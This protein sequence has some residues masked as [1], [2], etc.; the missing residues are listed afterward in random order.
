MSEALK[1]SVRFQFPCKLVV[2]M[3]DEVPLCDWDSCVTPSPKMLHLVL[4]FPPVR[5]VVQSNEEN[6]LSRELVAMLTY[7]LVGEFQLIVELL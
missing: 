1:M 6:L 2:H 7:I 3:V 4:E 5:H